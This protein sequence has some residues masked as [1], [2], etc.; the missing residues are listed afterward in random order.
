L[1]AELTKTH[2]FRLF[3]MAILPTGKGYSDYEKLLVEYFS[4][5]QKNR[6]NYGKSNYNLLQYRFRLEVLSICKENKKT[7]KYLHVHFITDIHVIAHETLSQLR[8][9][10]L[11]VIDLGQLW[12]RLQILIET[13]A[14]R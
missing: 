7:Q 14:R 4:K 6:S 11:H 2:S 13:H 8:Q 9:V 3:F 5:Y 1:S 10:R 12:A